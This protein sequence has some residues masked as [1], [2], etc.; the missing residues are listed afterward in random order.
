MTIFQAEVQPSQQAEQPAWKLDWLTPTRCRLILVLFLLLDVVG[1]VR[2]LTHDCPIDLAGDEAQYWDWSRQLDWSY[3]SKG[4]LVAY[5]I[6]ASCALFG[7]TMPA[8]RYP[9]IVFAAGTSIVTYLLTRKLFG[10]E[11]LALG[12][13]L[14][15]HLVPMFVAGSVLM[16]IDPPMFFCW[17]LATYFA[18]VTIFDDKSWAWPLV[19][20]ALGIGFLAKYA[21]LLWF[22]GLVLFM[23]LDPL[24]RGSTELAEVKRRAK[25]GALLALAIA[26][27]MTVP[28]VV[29]NA[30]HGWVS[31]R[32]VAHQTGASGGSF[33]HGNFPEFIASQ[34]GAVGPILFVMMAIAVVHAFRND[35]SQRQKLVFL[36]SIGVFFFALTLITS[37]FAKVQVNWPAPAYFTLMILTAHFLG[38]R[39]QS[40]R[41]WSRP[42]RTTARSCFPSPGGRESTPPT[43]ICSAGCAGG[44]SW[45]I[46][47]APSS[48][49]SVPAR[50]CSATITC[51][52]PRRPSM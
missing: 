28:V 8:V 4:P 32:H 52:Q 2:Y 16:T 1:H 7:N 17:A 14:L 9:A 18:A 39:L 13:V 41:R 38:T 35:S 20:L 50:S 44:S 27:C 22:G 30:Q 36:A 31:F 25:V 12:A 47:S 10:S 11:R 3:Y 24:N 21:T 19:G 6:R 33:S 23:V 45:A 34:I 40:A 48:I 15:N 37:L 46:T 5:I 42:S 43:L 29:W 51:R 26:L 49:N